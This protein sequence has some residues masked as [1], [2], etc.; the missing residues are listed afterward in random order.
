M[1]AGVTSG[2]PT[3]RAGA[4]PA[5]RRAARASAPTRPSRAPSSKGSTTVRTGAVSAR[6]IAT[7]ICSLCC[8]RSR[9]SLALWN[10]GKMRR[11]GSFTACSPALPVVQPRGWF[12]TKPSVDGWMRLALRPH[13]RPFGCKCNAA[14]F[15][16]AVSVCWLPAACGAVAP[17]AISAVRSDLLPLARSIRCFKRDYFDPLL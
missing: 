12:A 6:R 2:A 7:A 14:A 8:F 15:G 11:A 17:A 13:L 1:H 4:A 10:G 16:A 5:S 3:P 9:A